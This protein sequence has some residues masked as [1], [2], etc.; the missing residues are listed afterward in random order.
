MPLPMVHLSTAVKI[1]TL[2]DWEDTI[3][4]THRERYEADP[5]PI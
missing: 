2:Q 4:K 3:L 5:T 1:N